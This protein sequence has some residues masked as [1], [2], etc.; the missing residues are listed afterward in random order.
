MPPILAVTDPIIVARF[1]DI[2]LLIVKHLETSVTDI[3]VALR[4]FKTS[5]INI[6]GAILNAYDQS[7]SK[8]GTY[9]YKYGYYSYGGYKYNYEKASDD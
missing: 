8:Y 9:G 5:G 2:N 4:T 1:S 7:K 3:D 6:N